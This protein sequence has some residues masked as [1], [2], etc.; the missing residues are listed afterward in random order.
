MTTTTNSSAGTGKPWLVDFVLLGAIWGASFLFMRVATH[1]MGALPAAGLRVAI[2]ALFL[3]PLLLFKGLGPALRTH[4]KLTFAVGVLNSA[5]PFACF[6]FALLSITTGLAAILNATVPLFGALIAWLWLKDKPSASRM[7]GL[8]IGFIGVSMLAWD[9]ASF[10]PDASGTTTGWAVLACLLACLCYGTAAS[11]AKK[12]MGGFPTLVSATGSQM[13]ASLA[14]LPLTWYFWP[15]ENPGLE[16]WAAVI[17]LGVMCTG[18][19]YILYFRL[20][21]RAGPS[22]ALAVTFTIPAFAVVY[23]VLLLGE[24]VTGWMVICALVIIAGTSLSTGLVKLG[25]KSSVVKPG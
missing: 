11:V 6:T 16:A 15:A 14:L 1:S 5:I 3:L 25:R 10:K 9:K 24:T 2:A 20:I 22:R 18:L 21:E 17:V 8:A 19:A 7:L 23:G 12:F 13:G 4:W